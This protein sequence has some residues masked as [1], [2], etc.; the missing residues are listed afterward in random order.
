MSKPILFIGHD[1]GRTGAVMVLLHFLRWLK[2]AHP[3]IKIEILLQRGGDL[4]PSFQELAPT[5]VLDKRYS[6]FIMLFRRV[7]SK[8]WLAWT[9]VAGQKA[10]LQWR[11]CGFRRPDLIFANTV[12]HGN[13]LELL[14]SAHRPIITYVHELEYL[15]QNLS[16]KDTFDKVK[17]FTNYY[18]AASV[19]VQKNLVLNHG[20]AKDS[21]GVVHAITPISQQFDGDALLQQ[22]IKL[23]MEWNIPENAYVVGACGTLEWRK[24]ID[25]FAN[26][27]H[28]FKRRHA[29]IPCY[30]VWIGGDKGSLAMAEALYDADRLDVRENIRF[31][32]KR[33]SPAEDFTAIDTFA[34]LSR[35]DPFPVVC[36][37]AAM[38]EKP[39]V[40]FESAGGMPEFVANDCGITVPYLNLDAMSDALNSL[41]ACPAMRDKIGVQASMKVRECYSVPVL[42]PKLWEII[43][44]HIR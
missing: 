36:L 15:I 32:G 28:T 39:I 33:V 37:E 35:E 12:T 5:F 40:C 26:L 31:L 10:W 9:L 11:Y 21:I 30:F 13:L 34:L 4:V 25:L 24:G 29:N 3:E 42:A 27:A 17:R 23:R 14:Q 2:L 8:F 7:I 38:A 44:K 1:A 20:I 22:R 16:P 41:W 6:P 19:A 43:E 18:V